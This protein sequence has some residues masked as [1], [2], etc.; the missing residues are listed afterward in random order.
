MR[1]LIGCASSR[2][3]S[4]KVFGEAIS[5]FGVE[6]RIVNDDEIIDK[7]LKRIYKWNQS[8]RR[9]NKLVDDFKPDAIFTD[10]HRHF[11]IAAIKSNIP[12]IAYLRGDYWLALESERNT[13]YRSF[14]KS[15]IIKRSE[16][17]LQANLEGSRILMPN[18]KYFEGMIRKKFPDKPVYTLY[19]GTDASTWYHEKG[20]ELKH[21]CVGLV[22]NAEIWYKAKELLTLKG[23]LGGLPKVTFYW[24]GSGQHTQRIL[25]ELQKYPNFKWLGSLEYPEGIRQFLSEIDVYAALTGLDMHP[26]SLREALLMAKPAIATNVGGIPEIIEDGKSG[27]LVEEGDSKGII[28]KISYLLR[29]QKKAKQMGLYGKRLVEK[30]Y[31][32]EDIAKEFV[33]NVKSELGLD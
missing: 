24:A 7:F 31:S 20:M 5:K 19:Y 12:L 29:E 22:Q 15:L 32:W 13:N 25:Q 8:M 28:E 9:F 33:K 2:I 10:R 27:L 16:K 30:N 1:L 17:I 23:V 11:G 26:R 18:C 4:M 21:P 6:Y 14:P 3:P